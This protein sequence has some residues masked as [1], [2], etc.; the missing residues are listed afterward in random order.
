MRVFG[1]VVAMMIGAGSAAAQPGQTP[2]A[3]HGQP[4]A[5]YGQPAAP[6]GYPPPA[7]YAPQP[8]VVLTVEELQLLQQGEISDGQHIGGGL[9]AFFVPFGVGQAV[10]GRWNDTGWIF[11]VGELGSIA[12]MITGAVK[13]IDDCGDDTICSDDTAGSTLLVGG[14]IALG[15]FRIWELVDAFTG[16]IGHNRRV[17]ELRMRVGMPQP[18]YSPYFAPAVGGDGAVGGPTL[19]F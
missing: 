7:G 8:H 4:P 14:A 19:R 16:Q 1:V 15:V 11:T 10:Q 13:L 6:A 3:P 9:V 2:P 12:A 5:P 17:R 18:L